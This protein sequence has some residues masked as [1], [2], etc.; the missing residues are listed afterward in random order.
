MLPPGALIL[1]MAQSARARCQ[2]LRDKIHSVKK[3]NKIIN[4]IGITTSKPAGPRMHFQDRYTLLVVNGNQSSVIRYKLGEV[5]IYI[6]RYSSHV[7]TK[8]VLG[9]FT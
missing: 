5:I 9:N 4:N 8:T 2:V 7:P 1:G 6:S 3:V